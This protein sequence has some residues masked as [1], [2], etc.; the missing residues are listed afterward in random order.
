MLV[1]R[2]GI[3]FNVPTQPKSVV[4]TQRTVLYFNTCKAVCTKSTALLYNKPTYKCADWIDSIFCNVSLVSECSVTAWLG[5][6]ISHANA[7][8]VIG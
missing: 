6:A 8:Q 2:T 4:K 7:D 1:C 3:K 5:L